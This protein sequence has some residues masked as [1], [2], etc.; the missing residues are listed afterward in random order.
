MRGINIIVPN[1]K[2]DIVLKTLEMLQVKF[3]MISDQKNTLIFLTIPEELAE[4][5]IDAIKKVGVGSLYGSFVVY[6]I[7]YALPEIPV[8]EIKRPT[9][10]PREEILIDVRRLAELNNN[11]V[12]GTILASLLATLGLLTDNVIMIIASMIIAPVI[13]PILGLSL[14]VVLDIPDLRKISIVSEIVGLSLSILAGFFFTLL[15]PHSTVTS[16]IMLRA[17][18]TLVDVMF[19]TIAGLAAALSVASATAVM[20]VGVAIAASVVPPAAN[21]G[22]GLAFLIKKNPY[23]RQIILGSSLL[24]I[25]NII[26]INAMSILYFWLS[27]LK[28]GLSARKEIL[29]RKLVRKQL[30]A[31]IIALILV[32]IPITASTVNYYKELSL[33]DSIRKTVTNYIS[34][35]YPWVEIISIDVNYDP[36][37]NTAKI[38]VSIG[39]NETN[40]RVYNLPKEIKNVV[41]KNYKVRAEVYLEVLLLS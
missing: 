7:E 11:F 33:E 28:P 4:I 25:I 9:R 24:L 1:D 16:Q 37:S 18:P 31:I 5:V 17:R 14:G 26:A 20:L 38:R 30:L 12:L 19:A 34:E 23:A 40:S 36:S 39:I 41:E 3:D 32:L 22:I 29:A 2:K 13:G 6:T 10:I 8:A 15:M 27:G 21:I 35:K